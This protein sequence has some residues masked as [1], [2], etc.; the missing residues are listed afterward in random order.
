MMNGT[1][2]VAWGEEWLSMKVRCRRENAKLTAGNGGVV[3]AG[4]FEGQESL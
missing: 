3:E 4:Q 1:P 2:L